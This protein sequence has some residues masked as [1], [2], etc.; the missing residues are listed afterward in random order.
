MGSKTSRI[1]SFQVSSGKIGDFSVLENH[2]A[3]LRSA[4]FWF[5]KIA[6]AAPLFFYLF[7]CVQ[8]FF[9]GEAVANGNFCSSKE[10]SYK[11]EFLRPSKIK[12][13]LLQFFQR[14]W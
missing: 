11:F 7:C 2:T 9:Q 5:S 13:G 10:T 12:W 3:I 14:A 1:W 4:L 6:A 8:Y